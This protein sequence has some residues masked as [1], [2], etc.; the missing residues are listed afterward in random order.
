MNAEQAA[1]EEKLI[2]ENQ[3]L[4]DENKALR[5]QARGT[6]KSAA[7]IHEEDVKQRVQME[8]TMIKE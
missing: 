2:E 6:P 3:K 4:R 7:V 8:S 1:M 5:A